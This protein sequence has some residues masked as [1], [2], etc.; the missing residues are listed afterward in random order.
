MGLNHYLMLKGF[1]SQSD[2][3][4]LKTRTRCHRVLLRAKNSNGMKYMLK[5][6]PRKAAYSIILSVL[7][8]NKWLNKRLTAVLRDFNDHRDRV[9]IT[10]LVYGTVKNAIYLDWV[11]KTYLKG[12]RLDELNPD[13]RTAL[14]LGTYQLLKTRI[15]PHAAVNETVNLIKRNNPGGA[16]LVNALLRKITSSVPNPPHDWIKYSVPK[17]LFKKL[18]EIKSETWLGKFVE[19]YHS[20]PSVYVRVNTNAISITDFIRQLNRLGVVFSTREFPKECIQLDR[21]PWEFKMPEPFYYIQDLSTQTLSYLVSPKPGEKIL[22]LTAAPG[23]KTSHMATM[24]KNQGTIVAVDINISRLSAMRDLL[25][26]LGIDIGYPIAADARDISFKVRFDR[27]LIDVP[28]SGLGTL[29][30]KPEI[31]QRMNPKRIRELVTLQRDILKNAVNLVNPGG[32]LIYTTCTILDEENQNQVEWFLSK[33]KDF[34]V[35][36]ARRLVP[37]EWTDG[38]FFWADGSKFNCDYVFGAVLRRLP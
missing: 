15:P 21:H 4:K 32:F 35:Y 24:M 37:K 25:Q 10:N 19:H 20:S 27:V 23:G 7:E 9:L 12:W 3:D 11:I 6:S 16:K 5:T 29:R 13:V 14:R 30:R 33:F 8:E 34:R 18:K 36:P 26:R 17:W 1:H 28:C 22:D 38:D 31:L 2:E